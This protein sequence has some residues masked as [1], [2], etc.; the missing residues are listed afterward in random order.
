MTVT[1][2]TGDARDMLATLPAGSAR[3]CVTSPPYLNLRDYGVA[4]QI[5]LESDPADYIA[6]LVDVFRE[7]KRVLTDDG[8]C[9][10]VLGDCY[11]KGK[12]LQLMPYRVAMALQADGWILRSN[13]V[14]A[15]PNPMPESCRDRP[16]SAHES[17][18]LLTKQP[19]YFYDADAVREPCAPNERPNGGGGARTKGGGAT[20]RRIAN[21]DRQDARSAGL[22]ANYETR[23]CR[24]VW[25]ITPKPVKLAHFATFPP[26]LA[27]RCIKAGSAVGDTVLD[28]FFGAGTTGLAADRLGRSCI[29]IELNAN[30][31]ELARERLGL[32]ATPQL[33]AA[34]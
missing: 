4:G 11:G 13:I 9:W 12:Q 10:V 24:N 21:A 8:T 7:V 15:K 25:R 23:N 1:I 31:A 17:V 3:C 29:G 19:K 20:A 2:L 27:E 18:V 22:V 32:A 14:W 6:A 16:T 34:D 26:E 5:G 33:E 30:Y 28:P